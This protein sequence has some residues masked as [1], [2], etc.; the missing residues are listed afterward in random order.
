M[1][2]KRLARPVVTPLTNKDKREYGHR[3][4]QQDGEHDGPN[5]RRKRPAL[6]DGLSSARLPPPALGERRH[7]RLARRLVAVRRKHYSPGLS[8]SMGST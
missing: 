3:C 7:R 8:V 5:Q 2:G 4:D 6:R 1:A